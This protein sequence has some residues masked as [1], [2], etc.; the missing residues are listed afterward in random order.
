MKRDDFEQWF[1]AKLVEARENNDPS[2]AERIA[3]M[4]VLIEINLE[5][6]K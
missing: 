2:L 1:E 5:T 6:T 3:R 4:M